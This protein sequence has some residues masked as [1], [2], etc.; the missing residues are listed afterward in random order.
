MTSRNNAQAISDRRIVGVQPERV[1]NVSST[2]FPGHYPG[3]DNS[4]DLQAFKKV[5]TPLFFAKVDKA[6]KLANSRIYK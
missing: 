2:D 6:Y 1:T 4:W 5:L 3:E